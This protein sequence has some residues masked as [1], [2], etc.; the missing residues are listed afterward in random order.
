MFDMYQAFRKLPVMLER[1]A[2]EETYVLLNERSKRALDE[3]IH[4][5]PQE[6]QIFNDL[7]GYLDDLSVDHRENT[8][9]I[10]I[11]SLVILTDDDQII[12]YFEK[13]AQPAS[14][15]EPEMLHVAS[16]ASRAARDYEAEWIS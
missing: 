1:N 10:P 11:D 9:M 15:Y 5:L 12:S 6:N 7:A 16:P 13:M 4:H 14:D 3:I 8:Q 2:G